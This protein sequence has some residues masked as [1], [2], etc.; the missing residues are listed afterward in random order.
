MLNGPVTVVAM[1]IVAA[2]GSPTAESVVKSS[3]FKAVDDAVLRAAR[4]SKYKPKMLNCQP[5]DGPY[6]FRID[7]RPN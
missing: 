1:V 6:I 7:Y 3:G 5:V 4:V 2:D